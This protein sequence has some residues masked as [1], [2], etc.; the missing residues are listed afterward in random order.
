M[1]PK[2]TFAPVT[3]G[4]WEDFETLFG[5][6]GACAGCWCMWWRGTRKVYEKN[7]GAGN[8]RRMKKIIASGEVPG[9]LAYHGREAVGWCAVGPRDRY[10][11][12]ARSRIMA[13]VDDEPVWSIT[14]FFVR[15]DYRR[16][17]VSTRLLD[18]AVE[19]AA[20]RGG[21]I[22]EGYPVEARKN[23]EPDPFMYHGVASAFR[24]AHF[25]EVARRSPNRPIMRR[26]V[27]RK[28]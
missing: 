16:R 12:L 9:I 27:G 2:L 25:Q 7:K 4:R 20:S 5:K 21:R 11:A 22:V 28:R 10:A 8:K 14:C 17:G 18:A 3:P 26:F 6:R 15:R 23:D 19:Y 1:N 13:P 24:K